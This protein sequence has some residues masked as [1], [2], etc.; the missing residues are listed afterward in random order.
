MSQGALPHTPQPNIDPVFHPLIAILRFLIFAAIGYFS[1]TYFLAPESSS[2]GLETTRLASM[3]EPFD[4]SVDLISQ[5]KQRTANRIDNSRGSDD[6]STKRQS[7]RAFTRE[8]FVPSRPKLNG[9]RL[10]TQ[11]IAPAETTDSISVLTTNIE[12]AIQHI[13]LAEANWRKT[14]LPLQRNQRGKRI[15][16]KPQ[17]VTAYYEHLERIG[18]L[19]SDVSE[20]KQ[21]LATILKPRNYHSRIP[22][23]KR[24][25]ARL[26]AMQLAYD[27]STTHIHRLVSSSKIQPLESGPTL[28]ESYETIAKKE[29]IDLANSLAKARADV[30]N[31]YRS[32]VVSAERAAQVAVQQKTIA[33]I[34][35]ER[36]K[37]LLQEQRLEDEKQNAI[38]VDK[39]KSRHVQSLLLPFVS[40]GHRQP[41][42]GSTPDARG[43]SLSILLSSGALESSIEGMKKLVMIAAQ[44]RDRHRPRWHLDPTLIQSYSMSQLER[45]KE[46]QNL[47]STL[48]PTLVE[49]GMLSE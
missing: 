36:T 9:G 38:Y 6:T 7:S 47:L 15:A 10:P 16:H 34:N 13:G 20:L 42:G 26:D 32:R 12:K 27:R 30:I 18:K 35:L 40:P 2:A 22:A 31:E 39:C 37:H 4:P 24:F 21:E 44:S 33:R 1:L 25:Q 17:F 46:A 11:A 28:K 8:T 3:S 5:L 43:I 29:A 41:D 49:L 23:L 14:I 19:Q 48:G 45:I